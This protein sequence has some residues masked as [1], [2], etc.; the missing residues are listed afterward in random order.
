M[1]TSSTGEAS[2]QSTTASVK[3]IRTHDPLAGGTDGDW[4]ALN[5]VTALGSCASFMGMIPI[6]IRD[7]SHGGRMLSQLQIAV[8]TGKM[9]SVVIDDTKTSQGWCLAQ[10][11]DLLP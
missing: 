3:L 9:V 4:F 5:G 11:V 7:D 1:A 6:R 10:W 2:T 8:T